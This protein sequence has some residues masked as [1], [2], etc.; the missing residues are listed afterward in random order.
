[1]HKET[2]QYLIHADHDDYDNDHDHD[3]GDDGYDDDDDNND[4]GEKS[5]DLVFQE[6]RLLFLYNSRLPLFCYL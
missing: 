1:M 2:N 6:V 3:D 5:Y 4:N